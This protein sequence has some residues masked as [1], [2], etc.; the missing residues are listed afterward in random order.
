MFHLFFKLGGQ[1]QSGGSLDSYGQ[2]DGLNFENGA[3][4]PWRTL[5][6]HLNVRLPF[7]LREEKQKHHGPGPFLEEPIV[8]YSRSLMIMVSGV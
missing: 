7:Q 2:S 1:F 5:L 4:L 3:V 8:A 6:H